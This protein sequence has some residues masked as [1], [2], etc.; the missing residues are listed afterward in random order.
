MAFLTEPV[1]PRGEATQV[2]PGIRRLVA[3][4][5]GPFTY[6]GTNTYLF[7]AEGGLFVLDPGPAEDEAHFALLLRES[8]AGL[9]GIVVSHH[10]S[11]HFGA[12]PRLRTATGAPVYASSLF[13][14]DTFQPDVPLDEGDTVA[15]LEVLHTRGHASDHLCFSRPDGLLFS[16]DHVMGWNSSIVSPPDG[17]MSDYVVQLQRL[18]DRSDTLY[19]PGHGPPLA[20]PLPYVRHLLGNRLRREAEILAA[21]A[22]APMTTAELATQLYAKA[23][24]RLAWAAERNVGAHLQKLESEG[25]AAASDGRWRAL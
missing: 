12:V 11:D 16:G 9:A 7:E 22:L 5:P 25:R 19:L 2:L 1:P 4:N 10:H 3:A 17:S 23:D 21:V 18:L 8:A 15:G 6:H 20:D 14:D 13:A 24:A